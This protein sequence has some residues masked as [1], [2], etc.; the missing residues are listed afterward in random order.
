MREATRTGAIREQT[1]EVD[2]APVLFPVAVTRRLGA[3]LPPDLAWPVRGLGGVLL[4]PVALRG[5]GSFAIGV[6]ILP[7]HNSYNCS[8]NLS[9]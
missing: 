3:F 4:L 1:L 5:R 9:L 2:A 6:V 7:I 8:P